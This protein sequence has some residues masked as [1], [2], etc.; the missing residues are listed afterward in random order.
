VTAKEIERPP[1]IPIIKWQQYERSALA[2]LTPFVADRVLPCLEIRDSKQHAALLKHL[3]GIWSRPALVDYADP[4]GVLTKPRADELKAFIRQLAVETNDVIPVFN[5]VDVVR[6]GATTIAAIVRQCSKVSLRIRWKHYDSGADAIATLK[7]ALPL[8]GKEPNKIILLIDLDVTPSF[9][10][11]ELNT[12]AKFV[13]D[14]TALKFST[15]TLLS[16]AFPEDLQ[17]IKSSGTVPR[18]DWLLW[19][20]VELLVPK[21]NLG[22]GDY[23]I[24]HPRWSEAQLIRRG[25]R[26]TIKYALAAV[27]RIIRGANKTKSESIAI[28]KI[29]TTIYAKEY[30]KKGYSHGDTMI[31]DRLDPLVPLSK[32]KSGNA[33]ITEAWTIHI[34]YLVTAQY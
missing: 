13:I 6:L 27:W 24:L 25:G 9:G 16:G 29:M 20:R 8:L 14:C 22:Y 2:A 3:A 31:A 21:A 12:L 28:S 4:S 34:T 1:Y 26:A 7:S 33:H 32:K 17:S 19:K 18:S 15:V 11:G 23:G 30:R 10:D 5:P